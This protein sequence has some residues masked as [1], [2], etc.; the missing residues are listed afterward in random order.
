[1]VDREKLEEEIRQVA[2]EIYVRSGCCPGRDL[3]NWLEAERIV[4][5]KYRLI[6]QES[7][8]EVE[9]KETKKRSYK[10]QGSKKEEGKTKRKFKKL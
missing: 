4:L 9:Q 6:N 3:D 8:K 5:E 7:E 10:R 2:Y 1:M